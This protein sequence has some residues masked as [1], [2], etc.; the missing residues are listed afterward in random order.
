M[1]FGAKLITI[2]LFFTTACFAQ[3]VQNSNVAGQ[4]Y[5]DNV[6]ELAD[7]VD[8]YLAAAD[9]VSPGAEVF[10]VISPHAGYGYSGQ[11]AA[12]GYKLIQGKPY[13][14]VVVIG[15]A[16]QYGFSG[17]SVYSQGVFRTPL[18]RLEIDN[19]FAQKLVG[20]DKDI[21]FEP[22]AFKGPEHSVEVQLPFLQ[23]TLS[24]FKIVPVVMGDCTLDTCTKFADLLKKSIGKRK[25]VL[26]V[27]S[28][29]LYHGYDF[30]AAS[31]VDH[32]TLSFIEKMDVENLY[33]G[34][35]EGKLQACGGF[36]IVTA[37]ILAKELGHNKV[38]VLKYTN[39]AQVT[40]NKTKGNWTVGYASCVIDSEGE[41]AMLNKEQKN[42][43]L[44]IAR[45]S[46]ETFLKTGKKLEVK[47][48][49]PVLSQK[50][51]AFVTLHKH[52]QLRGCIGN[53]VGEGPLYLTVRDMA[54]EAATGDP[55][56]APVTA[57][58]LKDIDLEI[59]ALS[60]LEKVDSADRVQM[61]KH[62]VV[63]KKGFNS[64]VFLPQVATE[65][66]WTKEEFLSHLCAQKAGLE[67][68]AWK[69]KST[70]IYVFT[71]EVFSEKS[72]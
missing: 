9:P 61:G 50:M 18:G 66:G 7:A 69:D 21:F 36:G 53:M 37:V 58:E 40:G 60:P 42:K 72:E 35:R 51:G 49:D 2:F 19:D 65:T 33:Y 39:S 56:F 12:Y 55:R 44:E 16:H 17:V 28:S 27:V 4:F 10:A 46:I 15:T 3:N 34:L 71:A 63:I 70:Q 26:I 52:G 22:K 29:D 1:A 67:P 43:L 30:N 23:K 13:K 45:S 24:D 32:Q 68:N 31:I 11:V 20:K 6:I 25:D 5:P 62:G 59:S 54:V 14:T 38:A 57:E 8:G 48:A 41:K 64:G 47:V